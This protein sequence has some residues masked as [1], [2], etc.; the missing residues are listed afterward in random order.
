[1]FEGHSL[2][3]NQIEVAVFDKRATGRNKEH[4]KAKR[5]KQPFDPFTRLAFLKFCLAA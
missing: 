1:V 4:K 2:L 3:S 5:V